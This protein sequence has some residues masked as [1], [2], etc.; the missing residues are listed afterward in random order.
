[1]LFLRH[2]G[3]MTSPASSAAVATIVQDQVDWQ[4]SYA[5]AFSRNSNN[6]NILY[7]NSDFHRVTGLLEMFHSS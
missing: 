4:S 7:S 3:N 5:Q 2:Y 1:M 6:T